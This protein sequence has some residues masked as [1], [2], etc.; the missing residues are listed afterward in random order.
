M[1]VPTGY[2]LITGNAMAAASAPGTVDTTQ[3][4]PFN[5][6]ATGTDAVGGFAEYIYLKGVAST[7]VGSVVT[8]DEAGV[9]TLL[10]TGAVGPVAVSLGIVDSTSK[11]GW[12][13]ITGCFPTDVVASTVDN[14]KLGYETA[15]GKVGDGFTAGDQIVGAISRAATT[16]AAVVNCQF[17]RPFTGVNVA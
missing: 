2:S 11:Y 3:K 4:M 9:T 14:G 6:V 1:A 15:S 5:T 8:Y 12:Y 16:G 13:G 7:I 17:S 10:V